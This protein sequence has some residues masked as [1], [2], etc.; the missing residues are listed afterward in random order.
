MFETGFAKKPISLSKD[1]RLVLNG[2]YMTAA[3]KCAPPHNKPNPSEKSNC[4]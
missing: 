3:V 1:D 2:S 4:S